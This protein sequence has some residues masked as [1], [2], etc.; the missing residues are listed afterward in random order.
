MLCLSSLWLN[1][2]SAGHYRSRKGLIYVVL[3]MQINIC[4]IYS[5]KIKYMHFVAR[6]TS[7]KPSNL[8]TFTIHFF[9]EKK[10]VINNQE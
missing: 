3:H 5:L 6:T 10:K 7:V 9:P 4:Y 2:Q 1:A 8:L